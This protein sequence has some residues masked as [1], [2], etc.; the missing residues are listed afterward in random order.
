[1]IAAGR[2]L[3]LAL[4][5]SIESSVRSS[6]VAFEHET[7]TMSTVV[8]TEKQGNEVEKKGRVEGN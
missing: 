2:P 6:V 7:V 8:L 1:V 3:T 5:P 4:Q